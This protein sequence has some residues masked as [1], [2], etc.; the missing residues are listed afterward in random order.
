MGDFGRLF[1]AVGLPHSAPWPECTA[2][3]GE[4]TGQDVDKDDGSNVN[5]STRVVQFMWRLYHKTSCTEPPRWPGR[6]D[7]FVRLIG[8]ERTLLRAMP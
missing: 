1:D 4:A 5:S 6:H 2:A 8:V 3:G 7:A